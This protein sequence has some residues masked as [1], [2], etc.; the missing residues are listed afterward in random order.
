MDEGGARRSGRRAPRDPAA[1]AALLAGLWAATA[2]VAQDAPQRV[3]VT[4]TP[5]SDTE[6]RRRE[7]VAK[8]VYGRDELDKHGD[9]NVSDVLK[10]LPGI[11][12]SGGNPRLRG[13]G[14]GYTLILV[15]GEPAPPGFSLDN[16]S[17]GQV[18]RI[19]VTKGPTAEHPAAAGT[20][21]I[22]LRA[23]PRQRQRE[24]RLTT[25]GQGGTPVGS[26]HGTWG[27]RLGDWSLVWP[28]SV[29]QWRNETPGRTERLS[30]RDGLP[31]A[32][33]Q[34]SVD[35]GWGGGLSTSPRLSWR[36]G[37]ADTLNLSLYLQRNEF[38]NA[39]RVDTTVLQ[40]DPPPSLA[41]RYRSGGHWQAVRLS[42][43]WLHRGAAG[44][45]LE[46]RA[47]AQA[48]G[49]RA[50]GLTEGRNP[51]VA[52]PVLLRESRSRWN[53]RQWSSGGKLSWPI[54]EAHGLVFGWEAEDRRRREQRSL[55]ENGVDPMSAQESL[56]FDTR[57]ARQA[58]YLQDEWEIRP[59]WAAV[60][61]LRGEALRTESPAVGT[62]P[63]A[64]SQHTVWSP[65]V[66]L[67]HQ[68]TPGARDLLRLSVGRSFKA[69]E[70]GQLVGR[71]ALN[72]LYPKTEANTELAPDRSGNP[73]LR[74]ER[75]TTVDL[76][77]EK[78]LLGGG[79]LSAGLF[80]RQV[81]G[82]I[83]QRLGRETLAETG[84]PRWVWR[85][86]NLAGA[87]SSGVELELKGRAD[88]LLP[89][90]WSA[91]PALNL[92]ASLSVYRSAIDGLPGPND[93]LDGQQPWQATLG[94]DHALGPVLGPVL[95]G[96]PVT[97]GASA[98][99][100]PGYVAQQTAEQRLQQ[101]GVRHLDAF[102]LFTVRRD[103]QLRV[104]GSDLAPRAILNTTTVTSPDHPDAV[105]Q[106][107]RRRLRTVSASLV[108]KF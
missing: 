103:L 62:L 107:W 35:E 40:G 100:T 52:A 50:E 94:F 55:L 14:G 95:A 56:P 23:P 73:A 1:A 96:V 97:I 71:Y 30:W 11:N 13:L 43:Q 44:W 67:R 26:A 98:A 70:L 18:E 63:A 77:L 53:E 108:A 12:L 74:P 54:G 36:L 58:L 69:P 99:F 3:E 64:R 33:A 51:G 31:R 59:R 85:P 79:V 21:N 57:I 76:A 101:A 81:D 102:V 16:L 29:F 89:A 17:P 49:S 93:R 2:A 45:R 83:R 4:A 27:D 60:L 39:G 7:P 91:S 41:D 15:N 65:V 47:Q 84:V 105:S 8:T 82:L 66:H 42:P 78:Y 92:R 20:I 88:E 37:E 34:A 5:A 28:V 106:Q 6:Q 48:S 46:L 80:H 22:V 86:A 32:W 9:T 87:R 24:L 10:R 19:E 38:R 75:V 90:A 104:A 72:T 61:G 68:L 25:S